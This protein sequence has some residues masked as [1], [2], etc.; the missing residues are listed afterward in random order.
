MLQCHLVLVVGWA[1]KEILHWGSTHKHTRT[2]HNWIVYWNDFV[3]LNSLHSTDT[4]E[5]LVFNRENKIFFNYNCHHRLSMSELRDRTTVRFVGLFVITFKIFLVN[6]RWNFICFSRIIKVSSDIFFIFFFWSTTTVRSNYVT[7][8][9]K[10]IEFEQ[11]LMTEYKISFF[12]FNCLVVWSAITWFVERKEKQTP[13]RM[14]RVAFA[15]TILW[16]CAF[17][18]ITMLFKIN[19]IKAMTMHFAMHFW[20]SSRM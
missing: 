5:L 2:V 4:E 9:Q 19:I 12:T 6:G 13:H 7:I 18:W 14:R 3:P 17:L 11:S 16:A 20:L 15:L 8:L 10:E 1:S